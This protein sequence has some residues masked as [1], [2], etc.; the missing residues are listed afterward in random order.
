MQHE[1]LQAVID[2]MTQGKTGSMAHIGLYFEGVTG[3]GKEIEKE[4]HGIAYGV[5]EGG[6]YGIKHQQINAILYQCGYTAHEGK[7][8]NLAKLLSAVRI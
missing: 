8:K 2:K 1:D 4:A 7:A 6:R 5:G 3:A